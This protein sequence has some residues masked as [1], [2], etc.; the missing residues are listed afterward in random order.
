MGK[1]LIVINL[2]GV[3]PL[4]AGVLGANFAYTHLPIQI[5]IVAVSVAP[6]T[7][8]AGGTV[9][10]NDDGTGIITAID[11]SDQNVPGVWQTPGYGG[12]NTPVTV[13][14]QSLLSAD[15]NSIAAATSIG[16]QIWALEGEG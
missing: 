10:I 7:D 12:T 3:D 2:S 6:N 8:D 16:I 5:T 14:G 1:N 15:A 9:D 11:C 13:A 4:D